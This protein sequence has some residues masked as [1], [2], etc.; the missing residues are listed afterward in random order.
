MTAEKKTLMSLMLTKTGHWR[1]V[2]QLTKLI[3]QFNYK[4]N[5]DTHE[6]IFIATVE[7]F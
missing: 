1:K 3:V 4:E 5:H 2:F 6:N 7:Y